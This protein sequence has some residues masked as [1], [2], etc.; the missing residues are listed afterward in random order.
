MVAVPIEERLAIQELVALYPVFCDTHQFEKMFA[1]FTED[2]VFDETSVGARLATG[3][4]ELIEIIR[5]AAAMMGPL[6]HSCSNHVISEYSGDEASG[7]CHV[8]AEGIF[9][10]EGRQEPFR[11]F[12]YYDDRY[13]KRD[14]RWYFQARTLRLLVPSQGAAGGKGAITYDVGA[15]HFSIR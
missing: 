2:C 10:L 6:M 15:P 5:E 1:L 11:I 13:A 8:L 3:K 14:G 7:M 9:H 4:A 12:G